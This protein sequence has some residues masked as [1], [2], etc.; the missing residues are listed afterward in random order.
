MII[1]TGNLVWL[2]LAVFFVG[3]LVGLSLAWAIM[4]TLELRR[5]DRQ[6]PS[7]GNTPKLADSLRKFSEGR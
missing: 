1:S 5:R 2:L 4:A 6:M 3:A 7:P